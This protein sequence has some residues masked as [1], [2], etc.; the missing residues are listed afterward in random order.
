MLKLLPAFFYLLLSINS[1]LAVNHGNTNSKSKTVDTDRSISMNDN[2]NIYTVPWSFVNSGLNHTIFIPNNNTFISYDN[3]STISHGD[4]IGV[5]YNDNGTLACGGY[6]MWDT[7]YSGGP[8]TSIAAMGDNSSQG[9]PGFAIG[10]SFSWKIYR[11][12]D[13]AIFDLYATYNHPISIIVNEGEFSINGMSAIE[14]LTD[15]A[16][17]TLTI[18]GLAAS[19]CEDGVSSVLSGSPAGGV[20]S[21]IGIVGDTFDPSVSGVGTFAITYT[22]TTGG[23]SY[24]EVQNTTV[25]SKPDVD[26]GQ[27]LEFCEPFVSVINAGQYDT[28]LWSTGASTQT[29]QVN[30]SGTYS[31]TVSD[32]NSCVNA[33]TLLITALPPV[34]VSFTGLD[35]AYCNS[36]EAVVLTGSPAGGSFNGPG[37]SGNSFNPSLVSAGSINIS[38]TYFNSSTF[39]NG[40]YNQSTTVYQ[41]PNVDLGQ[42]QSICLDGSIV[43]DAGQFDTYLWSD[44]SALQ[45]L[46]VTQSG[47]Y[48]VTV[49]GAGGC[50][51]SDT[52]LIDLF[53]I[54][55]SGLDSLYL[56]RPGQTIQLDAGAEFVSYNWNNGSSSEFVSSI[57]PDTFIV[58]YID[59]NTCTNTDTAYV[60]FD[61]DTIHQVSLPAG[62]S[63]FSTFVDPYSPSMIDLFSNV[64]NDVILVKNSNG[65]VYW[66]GF[67][68]NMI[69]NYIVGEGYQVKVTQAL[70]VGIAGLIVVPEWTPIDIPSGWSIV[71]YLRT[72]S[73]DLEVLLDSIVSDIIIIKNGLGEFYWPAFNLNMIGDMQ[74]GEAYLS[75]F[76][77]A[78]T[79][80]YPW[81]GTLSKSA[82]AGS[83][84]TNY[85]SKVKASGFNMTIG[86]PLSAWSVKP[87]PRDE[88]AVLNK[89]GEVI[90]AASFDNFNLGITIWGDD[91]YT[92]EIENISDDETFYLHLWKQS[93]NTEYEL[94]V[95]EWFEGSDVYHT[96]DIS[97][98]KSLG[99]VSEFNSIEIS[100]YP[101]PFDSRTHLSY[102]LPQDSNV[103]LNILN[104]LGEIIQTPVNSYL[105]A[106]EYSLQFDATGLSSGYYYIEI[107]TDTGRACKQIVKN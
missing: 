49:E 107:I 106:G 64:V 99:I 29:I 85:Y 87:E 61:L 51:N 50:S 48:S 82:S 52:I 41:L 34:T 68:I 84:E 36:D 20:F 4:Y 69:G 35:A 79:F 90:G 46:E 104:A 66:P 74:P 98:V 23:I 27:D 76:L 105:K 19:Y 1:L 15:V 32:A 31:V 22:Y 5:F 11:A 59:T 63:Y 72:N 10:E 42:D 37:V 97:I 21:G 100:S 75:S 40:A 13:G 7:T 96:D 77:Q 57:Y 3:G 102:F 103:K 95:V 93:N 16:P 17:P 94:E 71:G 80:T 28:Y 24:T 92:D 67:G 45:T 86:I 89:T 65:E 6:M 18:T 9:L 53:A 91:P 38:Y 26:L 88:I 73:A 8:Y 62:W 55:Q 83:L 54:P 43:L 56:I 25:Y 30:Y 101:N 81:N 44:A 14:T 60:E 2:L 70:T 58:T 47:E 12:S 33:D 78:V 39:C